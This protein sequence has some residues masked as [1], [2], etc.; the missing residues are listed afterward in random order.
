[1]AARIADIH[2]VGTRAAQ[3]APTVGLAGKLYCVDDEDFILERCADDGLSWEQYSPAT[4]APS[5][6]ATS[7]ENGGGDEITVAGLS[8]VLAD[9]QP[10]IIGAG[11]S[12]A[13]AGN[14][15]RLTNSRT[16]TAHAASHAD[17]GSDPI[18]VTDLDGFPNASPAAAFLREDGSWAVPPGGGGAGSGDVVG[19]GVAVDGH[20]AL[21]DGTTGKLIKDGGAPGGSGRLIGLQR[22]TATGAYTYTPT[23]G[24][25]SIVVELQGGGG[26]AGGAATATSSNIVMGGAGGGGAWLRKRLTAA[27]SGA[28]G[29]VGAKGAGG[30]A[31]NNNG[32][33][34]ADTTFI[35]TGAVTYTAGG[36]VGG[37]GMANGIVAPE[38]RNV[39]GDGGVATTGDDNQNGGGGLAPIGLKATTIIP[40]TGGSSRYGQPSRPAVAVGSNLSQAGTNGTGKGAGGN[41]AVA[42]QIGTQQ[43]GGTGSD[44]VVIIWEYS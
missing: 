30:A 32:A 18:D 37:T 10:P 41:G 40:S 9:P 39:S 7:H 21:F 22:I 20:L 24:T 35:T 12:Q 17:G 34:G 38:S 8:G 11:G 31:G 15:A 36:G 43:A 26:G 25:G 29:V 5:L 33:N 16:P 28:T 14:D 44:G 4:V 19:P 27:F 13:V 3:P 2:L 23:A 42:S 1:M 6:H